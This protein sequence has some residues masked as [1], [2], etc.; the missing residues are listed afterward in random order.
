MRPGDHLTLVVAVTSPSRHKDS[1]VGAVPSRSAPPTSRNRSG[2]AGW[3]RGP[4]LQG[5]GPTDLR[6]NPGCAHEGG[7]TSGKCGVPPPVSVLLGRMERVTLFSSLKV[8]WED[9][10]KACG[11]H[12][13]AGV[14]ATCT[15]G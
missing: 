10:R 1:P 12:H 6:G 8:K 11:A 14:R 3:T 4:A 5:D 13:V 9:R 2:G 15:V 7:A